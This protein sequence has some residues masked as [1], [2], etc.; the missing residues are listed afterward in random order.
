MELPTRP[1]RE[2]KNTTDGLMTL[3]QMTYGTVEFACPKG[4]LDKN[5]EQIKQAGG[6]GR[7]SRLIPA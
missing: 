7:G 2:E 1:P 3:A 6:G 4:Q 5:L